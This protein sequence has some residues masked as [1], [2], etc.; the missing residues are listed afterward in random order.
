MDLNT[1]CC[2]IVKCGA[3]EALVKS[4]CC[5]GGEVKITDG[6]A[7]FFLPCCQMVQLL[8]L[9]LMTLK[10]ESP[11]VSDEDDN[12]AFRQ[13]RGPGGDDR[14][15]DICVY[16][17]DGVPVRVNSVAQVRIGP[18]PELDGGSGDEK[19]RYLRSAASIFGDLS[20]EAC[21]AVITQTLEGHQRSM[22]GN[23][24]AKELLMDRKAFAQEVNRSATVD[25][26]GMGVWVTSFVIQD[27]KDDNEYISSLG[28]AEVAKKKEQA[29]I[30]QAEMTRD[31]AIKEAEQERN[32][33]TK[34]FENKI[35]EEE[36]KKDRLLKQAGIDFQTNQRTAVADMAQARKE[37]EVQ[38]LVV[39]RE[40]KVE[41]A[42]KEQEIKVAKG[43]IERKKQ[44]LESSMIKPA[45]ASA[46]KLTQE[47]EAAKFA[48]EKEAE[49]KAAQ[50]KL[51]GEAEAEAQRLTG[52]AEADAMKRKAAAWEKYSKA[53]FL[54]K[55]IH[56]LPAVT[57]TVAAAVA[58]TDNITIVSNNSTGGGGANKLAREVTDALATMPAAVEAIAGKEMGTLL[59]EYLA[60]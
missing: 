8:D 41:V 24:Y 22:I 40:Q 45:H 56:Q 48:T 29:R 28:K 47:A 49:A 4:G 23:M 27:V 37:V 3:S 32:S 14:T 10:V 9:S 51:S 35:S 18:P 11:H 54:D 44:E 1:S 50:I 16:T 43:E 58:S 39:E 38:N 55:I 31:A 34:M 6:G 57:Q 36:A 46:Y 21:R 25:L 7:N 26:I 30:G 59:K 60:P 17:K 52:K 53:T 5:L 2:C 20:R 15:D 13:P 33:E 12:Q 42:R 19:E